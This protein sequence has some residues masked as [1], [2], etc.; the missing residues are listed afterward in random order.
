MAKLLFKE[1]DNIPHDCDPFT[2]GIRHEH[3][4]CPKKL[5]PYVDGSFFINKC[6]KGHEPFTVCFFTFFN[7]QRQYWYEWDGKVLRCAVLEDISDIEK[8]DGQAREGA[9]K[10]KKSDWEVIYKTGVKK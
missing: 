3:G 7:D 10:P 6:K 5:E 4:T 2:L 1:I 9:I 8:Y